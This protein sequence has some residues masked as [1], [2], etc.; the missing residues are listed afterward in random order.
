MLRILDDPP[1]R[2]ARASALGGLADLRAMEGAFD[3]ARALVAENHSIIEELGLPQ[4]AAADLIA[5]SDVEFQ[6]GDY[7]AAER[8]LHE[9]LDRLGALGGR[10]GSVN[11]AWRLARVLVR[12][13]RDEEAEPYVAQA[14][15]GGGGEGV[16]VWGLVLDATRGGAAGRL[17]PCVVAA[18]AGRAEARFAGGRRHACRRVPADGGRERTARRHDEAADRL[19]RAAALA[20]RLGYL[21]AARAA[22]ER[23]AQV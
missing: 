13:G 23:L 18:R 10:F 20:E 11:A 19:R 16:L 15:A 14:L 1:S 7:D 4:T 9:S 12:Q 6:A 3:E 2:Y 8:L 5:V 22:A 21:V 17:R